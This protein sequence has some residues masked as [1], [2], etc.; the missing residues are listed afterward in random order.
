M[1]T[2]PKC[3]VSVGSAKFCP[4]CGTKI[5]RS[6]IDEEIDAFFQALENASPEEKDKF[7]KLLEEDLKK[8]KQQ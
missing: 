5:V 8:K 3:K 4:E 2:C 1:A 6:K 7:F